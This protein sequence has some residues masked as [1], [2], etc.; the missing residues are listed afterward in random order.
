MANEMLVTGNLSA[1]L[2]I[3]AYLQA[4]SALLK[5]RWLLTILAF[6]L[7]M[8]KRPKGQVVTTLFRSIREQVYLSA[9]QRS[10]GKISTM[11]ILLQHSITGE[12]AFWGNAE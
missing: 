2:Q 1:A 6:R 7:F 9:I 11:F 10:S 3:A 5:Y 4:C 8:R 12:L